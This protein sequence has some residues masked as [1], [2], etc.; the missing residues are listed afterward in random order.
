MFATEQGPF[1]ILEV[2]LSRSDDIDSIHFVPVEYDFSV[3]CALI[4]SELGTGRLGEAV[5]DIADY[6]KLEGLAVPKLL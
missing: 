1:G 4:E 6:R 3:G 5:V 2:H